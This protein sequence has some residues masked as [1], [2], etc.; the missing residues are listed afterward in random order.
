MVCTSEVLIQIVNFLILLA[1]LRKFVW[2]KVLALLDERRDRIAAEFKRIDDEKNSIE[3]LRHEYENK[4]KDIELAA[5]ARMQESIREAQRIADGI[6]KDAQAE[7][8]RILETEKADIAREFA[9]AKE[10]LK[11]QVA[12]LVIAATENI[13]EE[14][15]SD[16][17]EEQ[18]K[19]MVAKF[20]ADME[21][22]V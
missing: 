5:K 8:V 14:K 11:G 19:K 13:M 21:K 3:T 4:L 16:T 9:K 15:L 7:A 17:T 1:I 2:K 12:E 22:A 18:D 6:K 20:I 10:E